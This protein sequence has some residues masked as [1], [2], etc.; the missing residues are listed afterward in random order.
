MRYLNRCFRAAKQVEWIVRC[1]LLNF[2]PGVTISKRA[3]ISRRAK[4]E[5]R[6]QDMLLGG[7]ICILDNVYISD[8]VII[9]PYGGKIQISE[10][11]FIGPY[12]V[13]Y[14]HGGLTIGKD[15]LI[16]TQCV[17]VPTNHGFLDSTTP[18]KNQL[19]TSQG[20]KIGDDVWL[21]AGVKILDGVSVGKGCVIGAGSVVTKAFDDYSVALG[22]PAKLVGNRV[23]P[24]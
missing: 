16:A 21:G 1:T 2:L 7:Q 13:L 17:L 10:G 14:G 23:K 11:V 3:Y 22:V 9:A 18:I 6:P 5:L 12:C 19:A 15:T 24:D 4:L 8:G 20:I